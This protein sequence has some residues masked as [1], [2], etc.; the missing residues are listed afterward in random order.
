MGDLDVPKHPNGIGAEVRGKSIRQRTS[1]AFP[2]DRSA[3][4]AKEYSQNVYAAWKDI[5]ASLSRSALLIFLLIAVFEL[6]VYQNS[7]APIAIGTFTLVNAPIVQI[8][9]PAIVAYV[10]YDGL[11]LSI[12]WLHLQW[13]Y[14]TLVE[15]W[16]PLQRANGLDILIRPDLPSL[17]GIGVWP[18]LRSAGSGKT[19]DKFIYTVNLAISWAMMLIIP[20]AFYCQAYYRLTQKFGYRDV[21]L[22][23]SLITTVILGICTV[24]Y[25]LLEFYGPGRA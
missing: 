1:D 25:S 10:I 6:L 22:W 16:S 7:S 24:V 9:L 5:S 4:Q 15:I 12:R 20:V 19:S 17:W 13:A 11:R 14:M 3:E 2:G 8:I 23:I 21:L 18:G